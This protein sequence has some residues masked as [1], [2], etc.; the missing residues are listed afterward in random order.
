MSHFLFPTITQQMHHHPNQDLHNFIEARLRKQQQEESEKDAKWLRQQED[1][2]KKRLSISSINELPVDGANNNYN[3]S[4]G[5]PKTDNTTPLSPKM[6]M[7]QPST[8]SSSSPNASALTSP[9]DTLRQ[10]LT[11]PRVLDRQNDPI[12]KCTTNVVRSIMTL[13]SGVEKSNMSE[14]LE[15]VKTVGLELRTLLGTVDNIS[16]Q[17]PPQT[18]KYDS[19][20]FIASF[21]YNNFIIGKWKWRTKYYQKT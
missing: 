14:Y 9:Q 17:F 18:H 21:F 8:S 15:L 13:S 16:I 19:D 12:Y 3:L 4:G 7:Q 5:Q 6:V 1:N 11:E 20:F 10:Q 2:I